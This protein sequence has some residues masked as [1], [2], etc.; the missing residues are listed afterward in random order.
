MISDTSLLASVMV[1]QPVIQAAIASVE[2]FNGTKSQFEFW[3][4]PTPYIRMQVKK[5]STTTN[6][7]QS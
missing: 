2:T 5:L 6:M 4:V 7:G 1:E 3:I